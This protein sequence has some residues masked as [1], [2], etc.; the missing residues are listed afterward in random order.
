M[1]LLSC[2]AGEWTLLC[3]PSKFF[4][5]EFFYSYD[6]PI[7]MSL[8][9]TFG[10]YSFNCIISYVY[11]CDS[12][13]HLKSIPFFIE[14]IRWSTLDRRGFYISRCSLAVAL[15]SLV[16]LYSFLYTLGTSMYTPYIYTCVRICKH[17]YIF[18]YNTSIFVYMYAFL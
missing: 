1:A 10:I 3:I 11:C 16:E 4:Y 8:A 5:I 2:K 17:V 7:F 12:R 6:W 9:M 18:V 15:F 13:T 14:K